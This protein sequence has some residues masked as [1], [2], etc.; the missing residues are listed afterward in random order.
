MKPKK[1]KSEIKE[2]ADRILLHYLQSW[3]QTVEEQVTTLNEAVSFVGINAEFI[4]ENGK[5]VWKAKKESES[6]RAR[7]FRKKIE[8]CWPKGQW[9]WEQTAVSNVLSEYVKVKK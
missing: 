4:Q 7:D 9:E 6:Q 1:T 5:A 3:G 8:S 2:M